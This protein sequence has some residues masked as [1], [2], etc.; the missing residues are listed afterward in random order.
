[1]KIQ[2]AGENAVYRFM[3]SFQ[4]LNNLEDFVPLLF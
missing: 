1:M 3:T 4:E 2:V